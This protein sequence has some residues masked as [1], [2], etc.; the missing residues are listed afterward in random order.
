MSAFIKLKV[1]LMQL[2]AVSSFLLLTM[3]SV[4]AHEVS[5]TVADLTLTEG[6]VELSMRITLES[7]LAGIDLDAAEDTNDVAEADDYDALRALS[8]ADLEAQ[9][10]AFAPQMLSAIVLKADGAPVA[11]S[12]QSLDIPEVEDVELP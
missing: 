5:P 10:R 7:F 11:L 12:I 9:L 8:A 3:S 6:K 1:M 4:Q 2:L